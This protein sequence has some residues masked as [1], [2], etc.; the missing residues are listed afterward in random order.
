MNDVIDYDMPSTSKNYPGTSKKREWCESCNRYHSQ[1]SS[2]AASADSASARSAVLDISQGERNEQRGRLDGFKGPERVS[3]VEAEGRSEARITKK[4][5]ERSDKNRRPARVKKRPHSA[6]RQRVLL[7]A[8]KGASKKFVKLK[9]GH[10]D[11]AASTHAGRRPPGEGGRSPVCRYL[12]KGKSY[13]I[14][15]NSHRILQ[16]VFEK[17]KKRRSSRMSTYNRIQPAKKK[18]TKTPRRTKKS[19]ILRESKSLQTSLC[20]CPPASAQLRSPLPRHPTP[21]T[22]YSESLAVR[23]V[24]CREG[25]VG[26]G[27]RGRSAT[28][29]HRTSSRSAWFYSIQLKYTSVKLPVTIPESERRTHSLIILRTRVWSLVVSN[30]DAYETSQRPRCDKPWCVSMLWSH[31][32]KNGII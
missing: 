23:A 30:T 8:S 2:S 18:K 26:R 21:P 27:L 14:L 28:D 19:A 12:Q 16:Q 25:P 10:H 1:H 29:A 5:V 13:L 6:V 32:L 20:R 22:L 4:A 31:S 3:S 17:Q 7:G 11:S 24:P 15:S 9:K